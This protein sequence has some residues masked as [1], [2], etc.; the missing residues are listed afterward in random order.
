MKRRMRWRLLF[1]LLGL[2]CLQLPVMADGK[3]VLDRM[4]DLPRIKGTVY[5]LLGM[6]SERS[7]Y[8]FVYDSKIIENDATVRVNAGKRTI[9]QAVFDVIGNKKMTLTVVRNHIL[10]TLPQRTGPIPPFQQLAVGVSTYFTINGTLL[11]KQ[12]GLP[13][14]NAGVFVRGTSI[15]SITNQSG[16]FKLHLPNSLKSASVA[17]THI[18]YV[19]QELGAALLLGRDN[20]LSLEPKV[21]PLQE[22]LFRMVDPE[23]L[24]NEVLDKRAE[25]YSNEPI[26]LTT[27]YREG[28]QLKNKFQSMSEAVF[29]VY[30]PS[31]S[32]L[33]IEEVKLLKMRNIDNR[34]KRDSLQ[35][36][37]SAGIQS[38]LLLDVIK[39]LP[40]FLLL[41]RED[42]PYIYTSGGV[43]YLDG[44]N[45]NI[46]NFKPKRFISEPLFC[47]ELYIDS[48][49]SALLQARFEVQ[50]R[51]IKKLASAFVVRQTR[52]TRLIPQK[53]AYTVSYT[54]WEGKYYIN[55]IR[56]DLYFKNKPR[57]FLASSSNIHSWFEMVTCKID[58]GKVV[59][60]PRAERLSPRTIFADTDYKFDEVFWEGFNIIPLDESISKIIENVALKIEKTGE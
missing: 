2:F 9:R 5:S 6:I 39:N 27:F 55:H 31:F 30:K 24:L 28:V 29:K 58:L 13:I 56:G 12:T 52:G 23:K 53:V 51:N 32:S 8:L 49:N 35:V 33:D 44:R 1:L 43:T 25:N 46:V 36:R 22:F 41:D 19:A 59:P 54:P 3:D 20:V 48:E 7:G 26:Y 45:V 57:R 17:F 50:P 16:K 38:C 11:D 47:G 37:I 14:S 4:V 21:V 15:G 40:N 42:H 10:I 18:G 60:F 34:K